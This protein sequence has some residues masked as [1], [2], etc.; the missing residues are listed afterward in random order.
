[1]TLTQ[2]NREKKGGSEVGQV[3]GRE[4]GNFDIRYRDLWW[5][6]FTRRSVPVDGIWPL[7]NYI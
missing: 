2:I 6:M 3:R 4:S 5:H 7:P 1:M